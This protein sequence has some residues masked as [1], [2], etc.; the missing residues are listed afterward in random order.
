MNR[1]V[2]PSSTGLALGLW[3]A[4][5]RQLGLLARDLGDSG[6]HPRPG[7][8]GMRDRAGL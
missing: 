7:K 5:L 2:S 3:M 6:R 1:W 8:H 4:F